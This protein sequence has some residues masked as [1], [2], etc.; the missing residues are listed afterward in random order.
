MFHFHL[1][2]WLKGAWD[3][4]SPIV[5]NICWLLGEISLPIHLPL[6]YPN[7]IRTPPT[8]VIIKVNL[9]GSFYIELSRK[10]I[11]GIFRDQYVRVLLQFSKQI[12]LVHDGLLAAAPSWWANFSSFCI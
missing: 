5:T 10:D 9:D 4:A 11:S 3:S 7:I 8:Q 2:W 1:A 12:S 6:M